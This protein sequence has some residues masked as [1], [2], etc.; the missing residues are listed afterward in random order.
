MASGGTR[1][2]RMTVICDPESGRA[3][4]MNF[5]F[6]VT[7]TI[8][9]WFV[10][11]IQLMDFAVVSKFACCFLLSLGF[12]CLESFDLFVCVDVAVALLLLESLL[13]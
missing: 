5:S 3:S 1:D 7:G 4:T 9:I 12:S 11:I 2:S 13:P 6:I 10:G 8:V